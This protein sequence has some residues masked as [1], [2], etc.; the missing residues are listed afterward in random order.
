MWSDVAYLRDF[1]ETTLGQ[2]AI[3][4]IRRRI[5]ELWPDLRGQR[6][7]G[8][9]YATPY[10]RGFRTE[11]ERVLAVMP[12]AQGVLRWPG[13]GPGR[14]VLADEAELPFADNSIDRVILIHAL[15]ATEQRREMLREIWRI[16]PGDGRLLA[17]APN[18]RGIWARLERTPFG[19]GHP[20]TFGQ[21]SRLL[22]ENMFNPVRSSAALFVPPS[23]SRMAIAAAPAWEKL[24]NSWFQT[25]AGVVMI[26]AAKEIYA[27]SPVRAK[28]VRRPIFAPAPGGAI[29]ARGR[30]GS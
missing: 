6:V 17:I 23:A 25:F 13:E 29:P 10:L 24:G 9:G 16:L 7:L 4:V 18:R 5:R 22:R 14:V 15:E 11:A 27:A 19:Y 26:E 12:A 20:F 8:I 30:S 28:P 1:Y 2:M 21:L 3:R